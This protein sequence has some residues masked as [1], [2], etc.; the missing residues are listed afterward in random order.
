VFVLERVIASY[1]ISGN[2]GLAL[3]I[4]FYVLILV[5]IKQRRSFLA[6]IALGSVMIYSS[7]AALHAIVLAALTSQIVPSSSLQNY[8][9]VEVEPET[10]IPIIAGVIEA[11]TDTVFTI[12]GTAFV[13]LLPMLVWSST[14]RDA[15]QK[16]ILVMWSVLLFAG[17]VCDWISGL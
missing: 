2:Y 16:A 3:R 11:D 7:T 13:A 4:I 15:E 9:I 10:M 5:A 1:A 14:F 6:S 8:R 17:L 12:V